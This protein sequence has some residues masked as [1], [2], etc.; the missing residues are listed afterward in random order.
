MN[1]NLASL[2]N[3]RIILGD[4]HNSG[5]NSWSLLHDFYVKPI[6]LCPYRHSPTPPPTL[7][8]ASRMTLSN[9]TTPKI[10]HSMLITTIKNVSKSHTYHP[11]SNRCYR[12]IYTS[13][14]GSEVVTFVQS[15]VQIAPHVKD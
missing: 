10:I 2:L 4:F 6:I 14:L 7:S 5:I 11:D 1:N 13:S 12:A 8:L 3:V 15:Y 9:S